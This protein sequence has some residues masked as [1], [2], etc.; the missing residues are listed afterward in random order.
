MGVARVQ[1]AL[2]VSIHTGWGACVVVAGSL[3]KPQVL[4][5]QIVR[6][7]DDSKRFCFHMAAEMDRAEA[8]EWLTAVRIEAVANARR[9]LRPLV[10]DGVRVGAVVARN[11]EVG[12]LD[13]VLAAHPRIH[14]AEGF[15]YRDVFCAAAP[16]A[17]RVVPPAALD[18]ARVGKIAGPPWGRDQ[19][20][21]ALAAWMAL[22][23]PA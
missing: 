16:I 15:F 3:R 1:A 10:S 4:A 11:G 20:L 18:A 17:W 23:D 2:G 9:A 7:L 5:N 6:V 12:D 8:R 19:R 21:A 22:D 13:R 14:T